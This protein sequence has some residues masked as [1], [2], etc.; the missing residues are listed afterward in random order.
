MA[1]G[2]FSVSAA[3]GTSFGFA[4]TNIALPGSGAV[5][6]VANLGPCHITVMLGDGTTTVTQ[7][8][9]VTIL[10]GQTEW[11]TVSGATNIA[12]V[13]AGGPGNTSTVNLATGALT[14]AV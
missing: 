10:A 1:A 11:L 9:G 3:Q 12:G 7:S 13:A 4:S 6:R 8:T 2:S 5:L 14:A